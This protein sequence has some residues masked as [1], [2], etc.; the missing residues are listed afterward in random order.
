VEQSVLKLI[1]FANK[2]AEEDLV[3]ILDIFHATG[4]SQGMERWEITIEG[5]DHEQ[6]SE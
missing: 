5:G 6:G 3:R 1:T 4:H 2:V